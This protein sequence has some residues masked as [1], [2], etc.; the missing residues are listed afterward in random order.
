MNVIQ[1]RIFSLV[2]KCNQNDICFHY[3]ESQTNYDHLVVLCLACLMSIMSVSLMALVI[4]YFHFCCTFLPSHF[5]GSAFYSYNNII[6]C[7]KVTNYWNYRSPAAAAGCDDVSFCLCSLL[8]AYLFHSLELNSL[9]AKQ[10]RKFISLFTLKTLII[11][12]LHFITARELWR[13]LLLSLSLL[14]SYSFQMSLAETIWV[15]SY[16]IYENV[17]IAYIAFIRIC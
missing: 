11:F 7:A 15:S 1:I 14:L 5:S 9:P 17:Y 6:F 8:S 4:K 12:W 16:F 10:M 3:F 2:I 13:K